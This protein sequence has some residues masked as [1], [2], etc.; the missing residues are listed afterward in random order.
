MKLCTPKS[1]MPTDN[2]LSFIPAILLFLLSKGGSLLLKK[3]QI[4]TPKTWL[5]YIALFFDSLTT[6]R[7]G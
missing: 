3:K 4:L 6:N 1:M 7:I 2:Q 5:S